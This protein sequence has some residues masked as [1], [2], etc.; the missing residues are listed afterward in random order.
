MHIGATN[1]LIEARRIRS[2]IVLHMQRAQ[3]QRGESARR[4]S[5]LSKLE[6]ALAAAD[7]RIE[8]LGRAEHPDSARLADVKAALDNVQLEDIISSP[9]GLSYF[10][11]FMERR[12]R[13]ALVRFWVMVNSCLLYTSP[14]P[15]DS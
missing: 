4:K 14:S 11:E 6:R 12:K 5:Y 9:S 8:L 7:A 1:S 13:D 10:M 3:A 15:R 2:D